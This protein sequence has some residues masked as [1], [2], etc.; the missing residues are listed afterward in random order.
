MRTAVLLC[1]PGVALAVACAAAPEP[2]PPSG[3]APRTLAASAHLAAAAAPGVVALDRD[4]ALVCGAAVAATDH[5]D[6]AADCDVALVGPDGALAPMGRGGLLAAARLDDARLV[7]LTAE[8]TLVVRDATDA[9][10]DAPERVIARDVADPRVAADGSRRVVFT[11][12]PAGAEI[13]PDT[14]GTLVVLDLDRGTRRV[15]TSHPLDSAPFLVPGSDDVLF[16]S[17]RTGLASLYLASPGRP[18]RQLTNVGRRAI[19]GPDDAAF[20]PVPGREVAWVPGA[21]VAVYTATHGGASTVWQLDLDT[22]AAT[23]LGAGR[24]PLV[25]PDGVVA[26][27]AD[28]GAVT[29]GGAR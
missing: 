9:R 18:A 20:V 24:A 1:C 2:A 13:A 26:L 6:A 12:L 21:R 4:V 27:G 7:L 10:V 8:R 15:V 22:G 14:T 5:P 23:R 19:S 16:V 11:Q 17:A 29:L 3:A 25:T 28:G